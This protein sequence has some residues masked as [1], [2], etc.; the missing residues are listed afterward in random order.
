VLRVGNWS[1]AALLAVGVVAF[2]IEVRALFAHSA[3]PGLPPEWRQSSAQQSLFRER[4]EAVGARTLEWSGETKI[5]ETRLA[6][7]RLADATGGLGSAAAQLGSGS[8]SF[9]DR[10][11]A[12]FALYEQEEEEAQPDVAEPTSADEAPAPPEPHVQRPARRS[13]KKIARL[14][15]APDDSSPLPETDASRTAIYDISAHVVY[16]PNGEMLEA[17]S[18]LGNSMDDPRYVNLRMR[19]PT[20][21]NVYRLKLR[22]SLFHGVRALRLVPV[23]ES[24]MYGRAGI[25]AHSYML[26]ANGQSNGCVSFRNYPKFLD[27]FLKGEF[28]HL[29]VVDHLESAPTAKAGSGWSIWKLFSSS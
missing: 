15:E 27:A 2:S 10:F 17:H 26:G 5:A 4:W 20:P 1:A 16:L 3:A 18:G 24:K 9:D 22:E 7:F 12:A 14:P 19:G 13:A 29:V 8:V 6:S 21:P 23:D 28:D 25:L 11:T